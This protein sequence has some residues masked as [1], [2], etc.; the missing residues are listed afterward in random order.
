MKIRAVVKKHTG[1]TK[2]FHSEIVAGG[3]VP[4]TELPVAEWV[5]IEHTDGGYYLFYYDLK[6]EC[7]ADTWHATLNEAKEQA[8]FEFAIEE[9]DWT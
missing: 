5:A 1:A 2:H 3:V 7:I 6:D 9:D 8:K 4:R